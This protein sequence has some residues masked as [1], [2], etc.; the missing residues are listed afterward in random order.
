M[1]DQLDSTIYLIKMD[2]EGSEV[3]IIERLI[4]TELIHK[5][6]YLFVETHEKQIPELLDRTTMIR[7][8]ISDLKIRNANLHWQ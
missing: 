8:K 5:I 2:I 3:S 7:R 1:I 6:K 4:E